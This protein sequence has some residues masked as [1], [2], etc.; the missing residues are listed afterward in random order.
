MKQQRNRLLN[1]E[2]HQA[3]LQAAIEEFYTKGYE[4][5][6]M[7]TI[8]KEA[9]VSKATVY[10]HFKSKEELFLAIAMIIKQRLEASFAYEYN[11]KPIKQ[12]LY[13][14]ADQEMKFL[15]NQENIRLIQIITIVM[16]QKNSIG[17]KLLEMK[18]D[19]M[20]EISAK[21]FEAAKMDGKL[22]FD[23]S[24]FVAKQFIGM[25]KSFAFYPQLYGAPLLSQNEQKN[26]IKRSVEMVMRLYS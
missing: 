23:D 9:N 17:Q 16:I 5:S 24:L 3:I 21:W 8:S 13:E 18:K 10:N 11:H 6:S 26:V 19:D 12:Q 7:D 1:Q 2:K 15:G 4:G 14:I 20:M 22:A 25:I